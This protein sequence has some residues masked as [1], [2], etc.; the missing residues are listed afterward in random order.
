MRWPRRRPRLN[1]ERALRRR[2]GLQHLMHACM[3]FL[4]LLVL[5]HAH[6][7]HAA[8]QV[9]VFSACQI[10][11]S[12]SPEH[13]P[14]KCTTLTVPEDRGHPE[15][16]QIGLHVAVLA[17]RASKPKADPLFFIA[18][19][20]GQASTEAY[21]QEA[22]AFSRVH[23]DRDLVLVDQRGTG[24]SNR[25]DCPASDM[26][27]LNPSDAAI[28]KATEACLK[29]LP[30]DP[31]FY[32]TSV[33]VEDLDAVRRAL[34]YG[35]INLYGISYGTRVALQ[36]LREYPQSTRSV[37]L[38][39]VVPA[40]LAVGPDVSL[41]AQRALELIFRRCEQDS[42]CH[43]A[44][45]D[46]A[47]SFATLQ[48]EL[49]AHSVAVTL[50]DP[51]TGAPRSENLDWDQVAGAVRLM[52]YQSETVALLPLLI[53]QAGSAH[54]YAPLMGDALI[55]SEEIGQSF[56]RG[57]GAAVL[58]TED[59]PFYKD[60]PASRKAMQE[61]YL[62]ALTVDQVAKSC[63]VWPKGVMTSDFKQAVVSDK[64]ALL[65]SGEDDPV[66]PPANA[67]R[68][69]RTLSNSLSLVVPGQ[70]HGN[71]FRGC[72]P[73]LLAQFIAA[74]SVKGLN[75]GCVKGIKPFPFFVNFSGPKP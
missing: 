27:D 28:V 73:K 8:D 11:G 49:Q 34:G 57:M 22:Q 4:Y 59:A 42:G 60:D 43:A 68:A 52:S 62:G 38:D 25:L 46:L 10:G 63:R 67:A 31:R 72:V 23:G 30:G 3:A 13:L 9:P 47:G 1:D 40:D 6:P 21:V 2:A 12:D 56:A 32:T 17:A 66:T 24:G 37:V 7:A 48:H 75:S 45:P 39:G 29:Q 5:S 44:F 15:G 19:G 58:C 26:R 41:D 35:Q 53:H 50:R 69:A 36:Y 51:L 54:D 65:L 18:G 61:T 74:A 16:K 71:V 55:F 64:P 20:P 33:A 14:A 70:G